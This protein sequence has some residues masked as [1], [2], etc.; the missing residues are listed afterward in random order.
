MHDDINFHSVGE[1]SDAIRAGTRSV[2]ETLELYLNRIAGK[3]AYYHAFRSVFIEE[4]R[5]EAQRLDEEL[6]RGI[7]R[8]PLHGIPLAVKENIDVRGHGATAGSRMR[9]ANAGESDAQI[10]VRLKEAGAIIVGH[11]HMVEFAF[12][13]WGTNTATGTPRNPLDAMHHRVP[14]GSS[15]GS[16]VAVAAGLVP[17]ALGTDTGGSV[18]IPAGANGL[19][20][21]KPSS[22]LIPSD[23]LVP[24]CARF[25]V[26]GPMARSV[27]ECWTLFAA[28]TSTPERPMPTTRQG[29]RIGVA[30]P[31]AYGSY[32]ARVLAMFEQSCTHL[33]ANGF[34]LVPFSFPTKVDEV[35]SRTAVLIGQEAVEHFGLILSSSP[36]GLD[37]GVNY[38]LT[39][40]KRYSETDAALEWEIRADR[41]ATMQHHM[42]NIDAVLFPTLPILPP[43]L[44]EIIERA[45]PL[46]D[47]TR[48]VNYLDLCAMA[49]PTQTSPEG[50]RHSIQVIGKHGDDDLVFALSAEIEA[51]L[52]NLKEVE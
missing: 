32:S 23:K 4:A 34:D 42:Q 11:T 51:C 25:D 35:L 10:V 27:K 3:N 1:L 29:L 15:S 18:R 52:S 46:G 39:D 17:L 7:W 22:G 41:I 43:R 47:L 19:A 28:M 21:F 44:D 36:E 2:V 30:D 6:A 40:A 24:L 12:G 8:G 31:R 45:M 49:V 20:G 37:R 33:R 13:G 16:G 14:G 48:V 26:V 9:P 38:R 5:A 50:L